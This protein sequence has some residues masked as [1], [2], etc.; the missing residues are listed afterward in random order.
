M[1]AAGAAGIRAR[2][3]QELVAIGERVGFDGAALAKASRLV[4]KVDSA[5]VQDGFELYLHGFIVAD[6]GKWVVVQQGMKGEA[7]ARAALS[8]AVGGAEEL[9]RCAACGDR[10]ARARAMIVNLADRRAA[11]RAGRR[12]SCSRALGPDGIVARAGG[13]RRRGSRAPPV[14]AARRSCLPHL[15]HAGASRR[16]R[17]RRGRCGGCTA[18]WPP[19]PTAGRRIFPSCCSCRASARAPCARSPWW[20]R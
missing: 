2:R 20:P 16:P 4:A 10:R 11:S 19:R 8:L 7:K 3:P 13:A 14:P 15:D 18:A 6:D 9:R 5:A 12:W 1:S 17:R